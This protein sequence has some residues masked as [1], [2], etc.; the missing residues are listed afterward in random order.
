MQLIKTKLQ[1][2]GLT[3]ATIKTYLSILGAFFK[4]YGKVSNFT[5]QEVKDYLDYLI[6]KRNYSARSRNLAMKV[7][8]FYFREFLDKELN[9][10]K[11]KEN[12]PITKKCRRD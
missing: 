8:R 11:A 4:H 10:N 6:V 3:Q 1:G 9:I 12:K 5:E 2:M 7:I